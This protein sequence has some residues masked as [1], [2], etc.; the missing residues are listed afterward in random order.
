[1]KAHH[2]PKTAVSALAALVASALAATDM[3][4]PAYWYE[5]DGDI[6]PSAGGVILTRWDSANNRAVTDGTGGTYCKVRASLTDNAIT[7]FGP[8]TSSISITS[9]ASSG[10]TIALSAMPDPKT[11]AVLFALGNRSDS[12]WDGFAVKSSGTNRLS[13]AKWIKNNAHTLYPS[14]TVEVPHLNDRL[15]SIVLTCSGL[16]AGTQWDRDVSLYVDGVLMTAFRTGWTP[17]N[18]FQ[19][20]SVQGD[21]GN[22]GFVNGMDGV[23]DDLRV[24]GQVL[25][26]EQV[27]QLAAD[28]SAW[29]MSDGNGI[30]PEHW[31]TCDGELLNMG[32]SG[33]SL[34]G[35]LPSSSNFV[36]A[37]ESGSKAMTGIQTYGSRI[38]YGADFTFF[39]S[40]KMPSAANGV[41]CHLGYN[42]DATGKSYSLA[43]VSGSSPGRV[44]LVT[45]DR[46]GKNIATLAEAV[47]PT[48]QRRYHTYAAV[49]SGSEQT[50]TLFVDGVA[51]GYGSIAQHP[52]NQSWQMFGL[53]GGNYGS[54]GLVE[55]EDGAVEDW[56][57]YNLAL[58]ANQLKVLANEFPYVPDGFVIVFR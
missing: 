9:Y 5:F 32:R 10:W 38:N 56:R 30:V 41:L 45:F 33:V 50:I 21:V 26:A 52:S 29:P 27:A 7:S 34:G 24:Y 40:A 31:L 1:M 14:G 20:F 42:A 8:Y 58:T 18:Q 28:Y 12:C 13:L 6:K 57:I 16:V 39:C 11:N 17:M 55:G 46:G 23:I 48:A 15:H 19:I 53:C 54:S 36:V 2:M 3:P 25:T 22:T 47:V 49:F 4:T 51:K 43:L 44:R 35:N 37:R